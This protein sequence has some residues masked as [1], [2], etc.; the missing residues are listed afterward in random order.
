MLSSTS[1]DMSRLFLAISNWDHSL[2]ELCLLQCAVTDSVQETVQ[3]LKIAIPS[4]L[5]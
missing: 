4:Y 2:V 1:P 3:S 5:P